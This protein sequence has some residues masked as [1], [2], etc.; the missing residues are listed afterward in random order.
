M[1]KKMATET[2]RRLSIITTQSHSKKAML[3]HKIALVLIRKIS[4]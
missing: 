3:I 4:L 2:P 1:S